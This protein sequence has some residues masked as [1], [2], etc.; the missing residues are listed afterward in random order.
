MRCD[1]V[2]RAD[3]RQAQTG[4]DYGASLVNDFAAVSDAR[5]P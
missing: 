5:Y 2:E 4:L 3:L 1:S